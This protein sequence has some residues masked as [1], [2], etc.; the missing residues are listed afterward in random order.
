MSRL[1]NIF[2]LSLIMLPSWAIPDTTYY[3]ANKRVVSSSKK[4]AFYNITTRQAGKWLSMDY[5][6]TG[7]PRRVGYLKDTI[8]RIK[9]GFFS[10]YYRQGQLRAKGKYVQGLKENTHVHYYSNGRL[11]KILTYQNGRLQGKAKHYFKNG[12]KQ[13][14]LA[15]QQD[16]LHGPA[17]FY[18]QNGMK[19]EEG[20]FKKNLKSGVWNY[21]YATGEN[22][23]HE[24]YNH[25]FELEEPQIKLSFPNDYWYLNSKVNSSHYVIYSFERIPGTAHSK[26]GVSAHLTLLVEDVGELKDAVSYS[27]E[28]LNKVQFK[29]NKVL[30]PHQNDIAMSN[31]VAYIGETHYKDGEPHKLL[32]LYGINNKKGI[33]AVINV[34]SDFFEETK[35]ELGAILASIDK[36]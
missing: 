35:K 10:C 4:A 23:G 26:G 36:I 12:N 14:A 34:T 18:H 24:V 16:T 29:V 25:Y 30:F 28:K 6:M 27:A 13:S 20:Y 31:A 22:K 11:Q 15:Y 8:T 17:V 32:V 5:Y 7:Q 1:F 3:D 2:F 21:W 9:D 19:A 33:Q